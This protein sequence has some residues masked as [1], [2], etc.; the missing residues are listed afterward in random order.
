M[1]GRG[2]LVFVAACLLVFGLAAAWVNRSLPPV[3][4]SHAPATPAPGAARPA[5]VTVADLTDV[6]QLQARFNAD[7]GLPRLVLALS[8][9]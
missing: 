5:G 8:P 3:G 2:R 7:E 6:G 1:G 9:T 4:R